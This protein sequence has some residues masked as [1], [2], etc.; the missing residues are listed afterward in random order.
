L[1]TRSASA[2]SL[3][4]CSSSSANTSL[5]FAVSQEISRFLVQHVAVEA[6]AF[7]APTAW[8]CDFGRTQSGTLSLCCPSNAGTNHGGEKP[9]WRNALGAVVVHFTG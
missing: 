3:S 8:G 4:T 6:E 5:A 1:G 2:N 9:S 7:I